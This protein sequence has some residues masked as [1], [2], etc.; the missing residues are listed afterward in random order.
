[1]SEHSMMVDALIYL[2]AAVVCVPLMSALGL[3]SVL[4]YLLAGC[5]IGPSL[6]GLV[7]DVHAIMHVAEL[8]VVLMLFVIG[9]E[10][11]PKRLWEMR[12]KV[13]GGGALQLL[14]CTVVLFAGALAAGLSWRAAL[15][16][17]LS[18]SLS[19][20]AIAMQVMAERNLVNAPIGR[21]G[22]GVLLFQDLAAIPIIGL[23]SLLSP[24]AAEGGAGLQAAGKGLLA[25]VVVVGAGRYLMRPLLRVMAKTHLR[26]VFTAFSLLLVLGIAQVMELAGLSMAL[27]AFLAGVL[28]AGSE[29]RR[30]LET[31]IEPFKGLL[32]GLF[33]MA[34][35]MTVDLKLL[36]EEPLWVLMLLFG[37]TALKLLALLAVARVL[38]VAKRE[39]FL[40]SALLAQGGE[41]AFVVFGVARARNALPEHWEAVLTVVVALSMALTPLLLLLE[42]RLTAARA[43]AEARADDEIEDENPDVIIAG[44]GR[45]GQIVGRLLLASGV[46][47]TVLDHDPDQIE[48]LRRFDFR[49]YYGD[50][51]RLD[52]LHAAG[53]EKAKLLVNAIDDVEDSLEL[54]DL[55]REHFPKLRILARARNVTHYAALKARNVEIVERETF[56]AALALGRRALERLS[57]A[58]YEAKERVDAFRRHNVRMLDSLVPHFHDENKRMSLAK[59]GREELERQF[60]RDRAA[61]D[62]HHSSQG[63]QPDGTTHS[64]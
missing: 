23:V 49:V 15:I 31:D 45:F 44:F 43:Q 16:A 64:A 55:A 29:Y 22:F 17:A 32:L 59:A 10:L 6:L 2:T 25:I 12:A 56:E 50:A 60:E 58:P 20:T 7:R 61:L 53:A 57:V 41:F 38:G 33:F 52:L 46:K 27:G 30:A 13:F 4:G 24:R 40:F 8:G 3:G 11:D 5:L 51:T 47:A 1:M 35:G 36:F 34:V 21:A 39:H 48:L 19:S 26:E 42:G 54:V 62:H 28:L 14:A 18:L 9:L 37:F 63:W